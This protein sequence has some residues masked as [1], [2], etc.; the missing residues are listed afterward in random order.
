MSGLKR[1]P[2]LFPAALFLIAGAAHA[3]SPPSAQDALKITMCGTSGPLAIADRAKPCVAVEAGD[4]LYFVDMGPEAPE[5]ISAWRMPTAETDA[6]FL[7]HFHSDHIGGIGEFNM[8][9]WVAGREAPL[10]LVGPVGVERV[11]EGFNLAY[12]LDHTYR[13]AH[14]ENDT[15][16]FP[17]ETGKLEAVPVDVS[18]DAGTSVAWRQGDLTV[19]AILV[20][21]APVA[22]SFAYRFD[23]RGRSVV[24]SGDTSYAP[25][26]AAASKDADLIIHEAQND[27]M[28]TQLSTVLRAGGNGRTASIMAD[29]LS[30]HTPPAD[31]VRLAEEADARMLVLTHITQAGLPFYSDE[32]FME[33]VDIPDDL[34]F[35]LARDGHRFTLPI[36]STEI[37][38]VD[39]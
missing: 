2:R 32:A 18:P 22:P 1:L 15:Y 20:E 34:G 37:E 16:K 30:Y 6:L 33:N 14:H 7:T 11:A 3:Q 8:Q 27:R 36:G 12:E 9:S 5:N 31:A 38:V 17:L 25:G 39:P 21:H 24:I 10:P 4:M 19:T 23:Y 28:M 13:K 35:V 26:L 29:T